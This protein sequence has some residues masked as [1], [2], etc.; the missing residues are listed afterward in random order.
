[1]PTVKPNEHDAADAGWHG[2]SYAAE[3]VMR[4]AET[5]ARHREALRVILEA[6]RGN[7]SG[8]LCGG[9]PGQLSLGTGPGTA[10][11]GYGEFP[12]RRRSPPM[13]AARGGPAELVFHV[14]LSAWPC[15]L[16]HR[17]GHATGPAHNI[18]TAL[19]Y[20]NC[21]CPCAS[22]LRGLCAFCISSTLHGVLRES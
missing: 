4:Y 21:P 7:R 22:R 15:R 11:R 13:A 16:S 10:L 14:C 5:F 2:Q 9:R 1:M 19:P 20:L 12:S 6:A 3:K 17:R 18:T 8:H